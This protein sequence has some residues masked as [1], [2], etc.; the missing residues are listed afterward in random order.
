[1]AEL[2]N[3]KEV[4]KDAKELLKQGVCKQQVF[5][6]LV[7][8]HKYSIEVA[9]ILT[10]LPSQKAIKKYGIWNYVLL[11]AICLNALILLF[12][13][14]NIGAILWFGLLIYGVITMRINYYKW[15][16][17]LS[18]FLITTFVVLIFYNQ[19]GNNYSLS[20]ISILISN[21]ISLILS[22]WLETKLCPKP[23]EEKVQY[24]NS[25]GEQKFKMTYQFK[26]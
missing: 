8:K 4:R 26:D 14:P 9:N 7:E 2:L 21:I 5:K 18:F 3:K 16:A 23:K 13:S 10:Y 17:I 24:T 12:N 6:T 15:V 19:G 20:L 1:M 11:V 22:I 25:E